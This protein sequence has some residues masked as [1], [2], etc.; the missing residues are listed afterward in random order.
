VERGVAERTILTQGGRSEVKGA[1]RGPPLVKNSAALAFQACRNAREPGG[2]PSPTTK[3]SPKSCLRHPESSRRHTH[4]LN[5]APRRSDFQM[6]RTLRL[7]LRP[8]TPRAPSYT[9]PKTRPRTLPPLL[10]RLCLRQR[11]ARRLPNHLTYPLP[12]IPWVPSQQ[13]PRM[14]TSSS[15]SSVFEPEVRL[16]TCSL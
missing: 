2:T 14:R 16:L 10:K 15:V 8:L 13:Q 7:L 6:A 3:T 5:S 12:V 1:G 9:R 11:L 4:R